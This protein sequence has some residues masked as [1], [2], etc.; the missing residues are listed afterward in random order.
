[1]PTAEFYSSL[2]SKYEQAFAHDQ[3][4]LAFIQRA[5]SHLPSNARV[6]DA[7]CGT[8]KPVATSLGAA[9]HHVTGF[10]ISDAMVELSRAAVPSGTF[11]VADM[12]DYKLGSKHQRLDAVFNILSLFLLSGEGVEQMAARWTQWLVSGGMLCV[13]SFGAED[14]Y[15]EAKGAKFDAGA[16]CARDIPVRFMGERPKVTLFTKAGWRSLLEKNRFE[17]IDAVTEVFVSPPE[18]KTDAEPHFFIIAK[19]RC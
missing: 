3:G 13:C 6:L 9:G 12:R 19:K 11:T 7:G 2:G 18:T 14:M 4:L 17:V 1:M 15:V 5:L 8:G 16:G 10:D